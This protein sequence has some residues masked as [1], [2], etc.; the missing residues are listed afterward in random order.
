[1]VDRRV[2][3]LLAWYRHNARDLPWRRTR[4]PYRILVSEIMLQQTQV[5]RVIPFYHRWLKRFPSWTSLARAKT[6]TLLHAWAGLGY[7][8]RAL[9]LR[10]AARHV[11]ER[12]R[13]PLTVDE[14]RELPGVGPY[15]AAAIYAFSRHRRVIAIDT[16]VRRVAG[17]AFLGVTYPALDVDRRLGRTLERI[18]PKRDAS[19]RLPQAFM[20]LGATV[21][22]PKD[23]QCSVCP[24]R[25]ACR[26]APTFLSG[27][28]GAKPRATTKERRHAKKPFPDRIYRGRILAL[29]RRRRRAPMETLGPSV[30][31]SFVRSRDARWISSMVERLC[32]DGLLE[33]RGKNLFLPSR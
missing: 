4:D 5:S 11:V 6:A 25:D 16:N 3:K 22:T 13:A 7:N 14:W 27:R 29:V 8:R 2:K 18:V 10:D 30:D 33:R 1:M 32:R 31:P 26:A 23:P 20:D 21:C 9:Q 15:T 24:L 19:W 28:A 17:R 12:G